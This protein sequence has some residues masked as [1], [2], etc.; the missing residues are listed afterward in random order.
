[1]IP[2]LALGI[3]AGPTRSAI[4]RLE[5]DDLGWPHI[6]MGAHLESDST[7][8]A[9]MLRGAV[10]EGALVVFEQLV[11]YAFE[12]KR[13]QAL[14]ETGRVEGALKRVVTDAGGAPIVLSAHE[15][16][17]ALCRSK[18][19]S[20]EQIRIAVEGLTKTRPELKAATRPHVYDAA[21]VAL[22]ALLR[23][24]GVLSLP[25][26]LEAA[27]H[28]QREKEKAARALKKL[29]PEKRSPTRAQSARRGAAA[30]AGWKT[31]KGVGV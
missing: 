9:A 4:A 6:T 8:L 25:P 21:G 14:I 27:I 26:R 12:A 19:A 16:R 2:T 11:G 7:T 31:R 15:W 20:D 29:E 3:D 18:T 1:M 17:A 5:V 23:A 30:R 24:R 22:V 28:L 10:R 13:V